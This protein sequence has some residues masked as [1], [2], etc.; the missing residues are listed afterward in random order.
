MTPSP[1]TKTMT[2]KLMPCP[3]C[4]DPMHFDASETLCH[5]DGD[6]CLIGDLAWQG[7]SH[8]TAWNTRPLESQGTPTPAADEVE[9]VAFLR[10]LADRLCKTPCLHHDGYDIDRLR[11]L[12]AA[13]QARSA[14]PAALLSDGE[15]YSRASFDSADHK[16]GFLEGMRF[17]A[18]TE[19]EGDAQMTAVRAG[20]VWGDTVGGWEDS[21]MAAARVIEAYGDRR[22]AEALKLA[23]PAGEEPVASFRCP[24]CGLD[25]PHQHNVSEALELRGRRFPATNDEWLRYV[26]R[27]IDPAVINE[28]DMLHKKAV[29]LATP[30]NPERLVEA[31]EEGWSLALYAQQDY[32]PNRMTEAWE[33]VARSEAWEKSDTR[34]VLSAAPLKEGIHDL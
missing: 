1:E 9:A 34:Q 26:G 5:S 8:V 19:P 17:A 33:K 2:E 22:V 7:E 6:N 27:K 28:L 4:G 30:T 32:G 14:E 13:L 20:E 10:D 11:D 23:E 31:F 15:I 3:F 16:R 29:R 21:A 12:A 25:E 18:S 24:V